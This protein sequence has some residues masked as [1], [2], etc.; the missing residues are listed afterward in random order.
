VLVT[1]ARRAWVA[2]LD[3]MPR[4]VLQRLDA[5]ARRHAQQRAERRRRQL[6]RQRA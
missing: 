2:V 3:V 1:L 4:A 6:M 5:W